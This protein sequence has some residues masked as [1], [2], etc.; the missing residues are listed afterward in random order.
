M[1]VQRSSR[2]Q[3]E[4]KESHE[5]SKDELVTHYLL[6]VDE[7]SVLE[8]SMCSQLIGKSLFTNCY[9]W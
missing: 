4:G 6:G 1:M 8:D 7:V 9:Q 3:R 5:T 2:V